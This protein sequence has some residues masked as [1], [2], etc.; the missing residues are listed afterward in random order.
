MRIFLSVYM[1]H[2]IEKPWYSSKNTQLECSGF[3]PRKGN[4]GDKKCIR[5]QFTPLVR[6][7]SPLTRGQ[8]PPPHTGNKTLKCYLVKI[9]AYTI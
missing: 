3:N 1:L 8:V 2:F 9:F 7:V 5:L 6:Q 4:G